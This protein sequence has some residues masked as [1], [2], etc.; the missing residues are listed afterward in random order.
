VWPTTQADL[1]HGDATGEWSESTHWPQSWYRDPISGLV[2]SAFGDSTAEYTGR[3]LEAFRRLESDKEI[4]VYRG[5]WGFSL[6]EQHT[7]HINGAGTQ[8]AVNMPQRGGTYGLE[9]IE[10]TPD[11]LRLYVAAGGPSSS[12]ALGNLE[13]S[14]PF[15]TIDVELDRLRARWERAGG[16]RYED[17]MQGD[18]GTRQKFEAWAAGDDFDEKT[19]RMREMV[20]E[21]SR[22]AG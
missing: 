17:R 4:V 22:P 19:T 9:C 2:T 14:Y 7:V 8:V 15:P 6:P 18:P 21:L 13:A 10:E 11:E 12:H 1:V 16:A 20:R 3:N 5:G